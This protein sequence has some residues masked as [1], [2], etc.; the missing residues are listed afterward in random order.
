MK[1]AVPS[2]ISSE[3]MRPLR[4]E[5]TPYTLPRTSPVAW[6]SHEYMASCNRG[7]QSRSPF[8]NASCPAEMS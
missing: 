4:F 1:K 6:M 8:R 7:D 2:F 5:T 3:M